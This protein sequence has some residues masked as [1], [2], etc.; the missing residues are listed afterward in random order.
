MRKSLSIVAVAAAALCFATTVYAAGQKGPQ[1]EEDDTPKP[2]PPHK[3]GAAMEIL[4]LGAAELLILKGA[5]H[6][7]VDAANRLAAADAKAVHFKPLINAVLRR[8]TREGDAMRQKLDVV[9]DT[10]R[11][12]NSLHSIGGAGT[13]KVLVVRL[14][15]FD[16]CDFYGRAEEQGD[17]RCSR[18]TSARNRP[19]RMR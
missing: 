6:A 1:S 9:N 16:R 19:L 5:A 13:E 18:L 11:L 17:R 10:F 15:Q 12:Y 2:L 4:L 8:M 3:T 14:Q 7:A